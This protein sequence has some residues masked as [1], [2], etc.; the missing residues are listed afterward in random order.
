M[1][2]KC[3][4]QL[5]VKLK[6]RTLDIAPLH[7]SHLRNAQVWHISRDI[8]VLPAHPYTDPAGMEG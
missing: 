6:V 1:Y 8:T 2:Y 3:Y 4:I 5:D 7:E